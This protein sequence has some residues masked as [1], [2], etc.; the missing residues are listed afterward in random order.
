MPYGF[1]GPPGENGNGTMSLPGR[2]TAVGTTRFLE[3]VKAL[4]Y[5]ATVNKLLLDVESDATEGSVKTDEVGDIFIQNTGNIP[6]FAILAYRLWTTDTTMSG[7]TYHVN[8]LLKP[9]ESLN[10]PNS[11]AV[12][13]DETL[14]QLAGTAV[15][16]T[17]PSSNM[18]ADI[19]TVSSGFDNTT[20]PVTIASADGD[21]WR[22]GDMLRANA[23]IVEITAIDGANLTVKRAVLGTSAAS[24]GDGETLRL[25]FSNDYHDHDKYSVCQTDSDGRFKAS[26]FFGLGRAATNLQG[27]T[28][29]SIC[30]KFYTEGA[31]QELGLS[32]ITAST[33]SGLAASG[34][35][36]EFDIQVD[37]ETNFDNL[38]FTTG[39]SVTFGGTGGIIEKIQSA[40]DTQYYTSGNLFEKKVTVG[41]VGGDI[42]FSSG[43]NLS[44]SAIALTAGSSGTAEFFGT[45]RIPAVG[46]IDAAVAARLPDDTVYDPITYQSSPNPNAFCFDNGNGGLKG[47]GCVGSVNY[48]TGAISF[49]GPINAEFVV[50]CLHTSAFSGKQDATDSAKMNTLKA[51]YGNVPNQK[52]S[53]EMTIARYAKSRR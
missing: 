42:R 16:N 12:I 32:G 20:D 7:T 6:A 29:G 9:G 36:Y 49:E 5:S 11:P 21:F 38:S 53:G 41:I 52:Q 27:L 31:Y 17:A 3:R 10:I 2:K 18:Y 51:I 14:E 44:T 28:P 48:E 47:A 4:S 8:Y 45:G 33:N 24:H 22:V 40:L 43:S 30:L 37:G 19:S 39:S 23:E 13:A 46:S 1:E 35:E 34:T 50:T 15:T 25:Q 26:N